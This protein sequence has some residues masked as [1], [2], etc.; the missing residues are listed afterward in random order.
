VVEPIEKSDRGYTIPLMRRVS[1]WAL[2]IVPTWVRPDH[3]TW[4]GLASLGVSGAAF[5]LSRVGPGFLALAALGLLLHALFDVLDGDLARARQQTSDRGL[6]LDLFCDAVG[7]GVVS[8]G[9][10]L[11]P[12]AT[13]AIVAVAFVCYAVAAMSGLL[14]LATIRQMH[15]P[16]VGPTETAIGLAATALVTLALDGRCLPLGRLCLSPLDLVALLWAVL[17]IRLA[18]ATGR[19]VYRELGP[20]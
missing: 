6:F 4:A 19:Y 9:L 18:I 7:S 10:I 13:T 5:A 14:E 1:R 16:A 12:Y 8:V 2:P 17:A 11:S 15:M 3:L 20:G